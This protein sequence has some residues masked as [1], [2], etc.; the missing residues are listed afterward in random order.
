[1]ARPAANPISWFLVA[2]SAAMEGKAAWEFL[3]PQPGWAWSAGILAL[4]ALAC[5]LLAFS[6]RGLTAA[7]QRG[8]GWTAF[9]L[10]FAFFL[11]ALGMLGILLAILPALS[12]PH[13]ESILRF[14][15][16]SRKPPEEFLEQQS[17]RF[18]P[19]GFRARLLSR[20]AFTSQR[21][22]S[23]L[24]LRNRK[25][26]AGNR[27]MRE[28]LKDPV[29]ELRLMA[30]GTLERREME[31]QEAISRSQSAVRAA[32][33][34]AGRGRGLRRLAFLHWEMAYQEL[35]EGDLS[36]FHLEKALESAQDA[37]ALDPYDGS[38]W[39]LVGRI[40]ARRGLW[41]EARRAL[42]SAHRLG[43]PAQR[44]LPRLA[45][46]AFLRRDFPGV[47]QSLSLSREL[48]RVPELEPMLGFWLGK[49][50]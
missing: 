14:G 17:P 21:L 27:L 32:A 3:H 10:C 50:R 24:V 43:A 11:P 18:G 47:R 23:L 1:M 48:R 20:R 46:L 34:D 12:N 8:R 6:A 44:V 15:T 39:V 13:R 7:R 26:P 42:D 35:A 36:A 41:D 5:G 49:D 31:T 9:V 38:L 29:D 19:G 33:D 16:I 37:L 30:Y 2:A 45:E 22:E 28:L 4:H 25:G 40:Q